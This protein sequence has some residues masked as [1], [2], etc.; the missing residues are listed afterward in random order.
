MSVFVLLPSWFSRDFP[1][2]LS[3][4]KFNII[5][6]WLVMVS[7]CNAMSVIDKQ[8]HSKLFCKIM[9]SSVERHGDQELH[10][11]DGRCGQRSG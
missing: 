8:H 6:T 9:L 10:E 3:I 1:F 7:K 5:Y 11:P 4:K 2:S